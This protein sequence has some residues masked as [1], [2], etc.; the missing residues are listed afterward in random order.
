MCG[1]EHRTEPGAKIDDGKFIHTGP[2]F[3]AQSETPLVS[4]YRCMGGNSGVQLPHSGSPA[5]TDLFN[6]LTFTFD[7]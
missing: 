2:S 7:R 6:R 4:L 5:T 1:C 3:I